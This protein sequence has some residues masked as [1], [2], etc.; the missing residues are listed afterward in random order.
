MSAGVEAASGAAVIT[1]DAVAPPRT[2]PRVAEEMVG[3]SRYSYN[4]KKK[5]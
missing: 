2:D 1:I 5:D 3:G 4:K